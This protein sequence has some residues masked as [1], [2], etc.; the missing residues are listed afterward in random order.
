[1]VGLIQF[2]ANSALWFYIPL[3]LI[4]L[5]LLRRLQLA[6]RERN[7]SIFTLERE[8]A[9]AKIMKTF[10]YLML[11]LLVALGIFYT[12]TELVA[13]IPTPEATPTPTVVT[14]LPPTPTTPPLLPTPTATLTP[15]PSPTPT[16]AFSVEA[17]PTPA[18][19]APVSANG[20]PPNCPIP[21]V[22]ITQ[23]GN[24][25]VVSGSVA[26]IG[27]AY[28]DDF[29]YYKLEFRVPGQAWSFIQDYSTPN[30]GGQI[31]AW[32]SDTV[33]PGEYELRLVVVDSIG[34][35]PTPCSVRVQV[36]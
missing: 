5:V 23:P 25:A 27:A 32:N 34:N 6:Y 18:E 4:A 13:Q 31:G 12:S 28:A 33:P 26:V 36:Q 21:G 22:S 10:V 16:A 8:S 24:G 30:Y 17:T 3:I 1:M 11:V 19:V 7:R 2:I 9:T 20:T 14:E 35:Y 15:Q 29:D